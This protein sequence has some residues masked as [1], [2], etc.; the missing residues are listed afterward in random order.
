MNSRLFKIQINKISVSLLLSGFIFLTASKATE[1]MPPIEETNFE[2]CPPV[3]IIISE[4]KKNY[5]SRTRWEFETSDE[6]ESHY[7]NEKSA[8]WE[9]EKEINLSEI[10]N[11]VNIRGR[12]ARFPTPT[13]YTNHPII[14]WNDNQWSWHLILTP[15]SQIPVLSDKFNAR[16]DAKEQVENITWIK[17]KGW[18]PGWRIFYTLYSEQKEYKLILEPS[19]RW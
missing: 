13:Y 7:V 15:D 10:K 19:K 4:M 8:K 6:S 5:I 11:H 16:F 3:D 1:T 18:L 2:G 9:D 14:L 12:I 17:G